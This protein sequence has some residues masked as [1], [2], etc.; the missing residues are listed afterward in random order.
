MH[1]VPVLQTVGLC[2]SEILCFCTRSFPSL[3]KYLNAKKTDAAKFIYFQTLGKSKIVHWCMGVM[4][5]RICQ[6]WCVCH[7]TIAI[8][9]VVLRCLSTA[10]M[11]L[12]SVVFACLILQIK[13]AASAS[14]LSLITQCTSPSGKPHC[15]SF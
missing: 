14:D 8:H 6:S 7:C 10:A 15:S 13:E 3:T 11:L 1:L 9:K 12:A 5:D 2:F 4:S